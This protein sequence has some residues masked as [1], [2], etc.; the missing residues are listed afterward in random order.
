MVFLVNVNVDVGPSEVE[1]EA[2]AAM[3]PVMCRV[4]CARPV[5]WI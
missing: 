5:S 4:R 1:V 2:G 3:M